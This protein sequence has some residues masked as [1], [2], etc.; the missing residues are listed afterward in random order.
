M[1][2][3]FLDIDGVLNG[4][5][6][7]PNGYCGIRFDCAARLN[8]ILEE[9]PNARLVISSAWRYMVLKS[10]MTIN[11]FEYLLMACGVDA[12]GKLHGVTAVDPS[13]TALKH[14][15]QQDGLLWRA[16]QIRD[17]LSTA[18]LYNR[19]H[20]LVLD[21]LPIPVPRL[22]QTDGTKGLTDADAEKA[23]KLLSE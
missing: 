23:I 4:H 15:E 17:Y 13:Q 1:R 9:V 19:D 20:F 5:E 12:K 7:F 16:V 2:L 11:G 10:D 21:D 14:W 18:P 8:R 3:I 6:K 22:I